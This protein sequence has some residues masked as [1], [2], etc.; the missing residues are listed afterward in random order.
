VVDDYVLQVVEVI[1]IT[2]CNSG[3]TPNGLF[4][5]FASIAFS[6]RNIQCSL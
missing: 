5:K 4:F 2:E 1:S 3:T 6:E